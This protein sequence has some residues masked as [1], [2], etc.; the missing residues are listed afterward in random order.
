MVCGGGLLQQWSV[1]V[2]DGTQAIHRHPDALPRY[3]SQLSDVPRLCLHIE[4]EPSG[5]LT[6]TLSL[7]R[8]LM[9]FGERCAAGAM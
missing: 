9:E 6:W 3:H 8:R 2:F 7:A 1:D 5:L 4:R